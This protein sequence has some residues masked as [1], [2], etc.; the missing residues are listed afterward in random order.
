VLLSASQKMWDYAAGAL[1]AAEAGAGLATLEEDDFWA[2]PAFS[3]SAVA[4]R[5]PQLLAEW[6]DWIRAGLSE[7]HARRV[8]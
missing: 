7:A 2:T 1:V 5:S 3:K 8:E 6:R 4:A